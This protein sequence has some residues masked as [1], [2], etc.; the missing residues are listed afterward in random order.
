MVAVG[1]APSFVFARRDA[2]AR[3]SAPSLSQPTLNDDFLDVL[4]AL[5]EAG[6]EFLVVGAHALAAHGIV[7]ATGDLDV[8]VRA[9]PENAVRVVVA[10]KIFGAPLAQ[11]A[12]TAED[13]TRLGTVY[14]MGLPPRRIDVLT[15]ISGVSFD[16][17]WAARREIVVSEI[18]VGFLG[19]TDLIKNKRAAGRDKDLADVKRLEESEED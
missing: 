9:S 6:V 17:A 13:F 16:E 11:H 15:E 12:V 8:W 4:A 5:A 2:R 10:L 19:R 3:G 7:R 18:T 14:Q 1:P